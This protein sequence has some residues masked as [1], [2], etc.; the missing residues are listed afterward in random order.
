MKCLYFKTQ[1]TDITI[2]AFIFYISNY[3]R[4]LKL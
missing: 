4:N 2:K 3:S 1:N